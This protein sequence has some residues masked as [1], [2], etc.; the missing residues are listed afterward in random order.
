MVPPSSETDRARPGS[1]KPSRVVTLLTDFGLDDTYVGAM[2]GVLLRACPGVV[3]VDLTHGVAPQAVLQ[4]AWHLRCAWRYFPAGTVHVCVVD[5]GVGS[6]RRI[7]AARDGGHAFLAPDN[8]LLGPVLSPDATV[9]ALDVERFALPERSATFHGR[10]VLAPAAAAI[11]GGLAPEEAGPEAGAWLR[12]SLPGTREEPGG[13]ATEV[14]YAD[15][16]GNLVTPLPAERL[17]G[18]AASWSVEVCGVEMP[19]RRTYTEARPGE[20]LALI[21]SCGSLE[22]SVREGDAARR[23]GAGPGTAVRVRRKGAKEP[24]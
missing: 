16:F 19:I 7:L 1:W 24:R 18:G 22:V 8:G 10:D 21:G 14:L 5:P 6:S 9:A 2:K 12:A 23:L 4:A 20:C 15:R 3:A 13:L 11:A 17:T